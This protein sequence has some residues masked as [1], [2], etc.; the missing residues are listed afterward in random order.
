MRDAARSTR[1]LLVE[2]NP[3]D[4]YLVRMFFERLGLDIELEVAGDGEL[5]LELLGLDGAAEPP[6]A[7]ELVL[8]DLNLPRIDGW[9]LLRR[10]KAD[11][12]LTVV[13]VV[14]LSSAQSEHEVERCYRL[15]A[16]AFVPKL[17]GP[18]EM[19]STLRSLSEFWFH[20]AS[21]P[22]C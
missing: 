19:E 13:P 4:V 16:S 10:I 5:A 7:P 1:V 14:I 3:A 12:R 11:P 17:E 2:D 21:L 20:R 15:H 6:P 8:L 9:E 18:R 22:R